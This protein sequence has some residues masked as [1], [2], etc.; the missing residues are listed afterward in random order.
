[1]KKITGLLIFA[2]IAAT[3]LWS[4][5]TYPKVG[6]LAYSVAMSSEA[7]LYGFDKKRVNIGDMHLS[8]YEG[9]NSEKPTLLM[10]HGYSADKVVWLRFARHFTDD[11]HVL[12][13]DMA[14]HGET[15]FDPQ[16]DYRI[17]SQAQRLTMLLDKLA[18]PEVHIIGNSMGGYISAYFAK[19]YP[20]RTL[21]ATLV[22]P[23]G[24]ESPVP[25]DMEAML[26]NGR[27]PFEIHSRKQFREFYAMTMAK[28]PWVPGFVLDAMAEDYQ[29]RRPQLA[30]I[31]TDIR[32]STPLDQQLDQITAPVLLLWGR[33]DRLLHVSSVKVWQAGIPHSQVQI[34][35]DIGHMPMLEIPAESARRY[36]EFLQQL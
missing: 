6:Q 25:S 23:A 10:L 3:L 12:I 21:S 28:P 22:D 20:Q 8:L 34:W 30:R 26:A 14:G 17:E 1:M 11:Y 4:S 24:V 36:R 33:D 9:G 19:A 16:W 31:F 18:I 35:N 15:G 29:Q 2:F 13:P 27:N 7:L 5:F 32:S